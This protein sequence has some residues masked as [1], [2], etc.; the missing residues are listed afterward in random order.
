MTTSLLRA[1][2]VVLFAGLLAL[3]PA[4]CAEIVV[5][6]AVGGHEFVGISLSGEI[7]RGDDLVF[8]RLVGSGRKVWLHLESAGGDVDAAMGIGSVV[9]KREGLV[10][11]GNCNSACVLIFAGGVVRG[12][13]GMFDEPV[14]GVHRIFFA[15]LQPG[16]TPKQVKALYDAQL[17][18]VRG[19][20]AEMNVAPELLSFMQSIEPGDMHVLTREE[21]NR[22]GL[23]S[24][25]VTYNE[26]LVAERAGELGI[27]S[28]EYRR[29]EQRGRD[30][31]KDIAGT[32]ME[33]T[34]AEREMA[35]HW[36]TSIE[37]YRQVECAQAFHYG[38][39][40]ETYRKRSSQANE[41]CRRYTDQTQQNR[42]Q[43]H[44]MATGRAVP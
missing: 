7:K 2:S 27:S 40:L 34:E 25:D 17:N 29:R 6:G 3:N 33:P 18:R 4:R 10:F 37:I 31:C 22:Y 36:G 11:A 28:L 21:L 23:R 42:C 41:R 24:Q 15:E 19:Y 26:F 16:H 39:S 30:E 20:L 38:T 5:D 12:G 8:A 14:I 44:F 9:R 13:A 35:A 1:I 43:V 32:A